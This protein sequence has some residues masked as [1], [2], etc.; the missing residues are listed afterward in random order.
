MSLADGR[1]AL[2]RRSFAEARKAFAQAVSLNPSADAYEGLGDAAM[3]LDDG[4]AAIDAYEEAFR[5]HRAEGNDTDA[6]RVAVWLAMAFHDFRGQVAV[7]RGW[8]A[9]GRSLTADDPAAAGVHAL[10]VGL[11]GYM[12]LLRESQPSAALPAITEARRIAHAH[13]ETGP[14][15][16]MLALEGLARVTLGDVHQ[17]MRMLDEASAAVAAGE[18]VEPTFASTIYCFV[19]NACERVR[20]IDRAGQWCDTMAA[21]CARVGDET[22]GQ[23]CRT[24]YAGVL[25]SRGAWS[26]RSRH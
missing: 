5:R 25:L 21:Y 22:M 11:E 18:V 1:E 20:D 19:I 14:E 13:A 15:M 17:G 9:R 7:T 24:L 3:M 12:T 16:T 6:A 10:A 23:Q 2:E 4:D 8:L 26:R